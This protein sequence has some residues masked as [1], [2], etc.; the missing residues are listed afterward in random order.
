M[1]VPFYVT[2]LTAFLL[3]GCAQTGHQ[4]HLAPEPALS[5]A[6][7]GQGVRLH[8]R[9]SDARDERAYLG[10]LENRRGEDA[11]VTTEQDMGEVLA[12]AAVRAL[13]TRGFEPTEVADR[14]LL[15]SLKSLQHRVSTQVPREIETRVVLTFEADNGERTMTGHARYGRTE[16]ASGRTTAENNAAYLDAALSAAMERLLRDEVLE[17]LRD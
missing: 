15:V 9:G 8:V 14:S 13:Q 4:V 12:D 2:V 10:T 16:R 3:V 7:S 11:R 5:E 6:V 1:K 17:F